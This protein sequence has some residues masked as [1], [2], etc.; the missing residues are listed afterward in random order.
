MIA[1]AQKKNCRAK[2]SFALKETP[3]LKI[4]GRKKKKKYPG[5]AKADSYSSAKAAVFFS[6][7]R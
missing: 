1:L 7:W 2:A 6:L 3:P 5:G 4:P